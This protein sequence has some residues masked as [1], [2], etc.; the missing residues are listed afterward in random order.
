MNTNFKVIGLMR[1]RIKIKS[2]ASAV[3]TLTTRPSELFSLQKTAN[4]KSNQK[5]GNILQLVTLNV[6]NNFNNSFWFRIE[7]LHN[8]FCWLCR[9]G[10]ETLFLR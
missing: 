1:L 5:H 3:D 2:A 10:G 8:I 4:T 7:M 9:Q 6:N